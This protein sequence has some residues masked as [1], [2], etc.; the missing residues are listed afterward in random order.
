[1]LW[2][3]VSYLYSSS[4][5]SFRCKTSGLQGFCKCFFGLKAKS[6]LHI[7]AVLPKPLQI[8]CALWKSILSSCKTV[9]T[10]NILWK[11]FCGQQQLSEGWFKPKSHANKKPDSK[12]RIWMAAESN[13]LHLMQK[14]KNKKRDWNATMPKHS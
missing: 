2:C 7:F 11:G 3:L 8:N 12:C 6:N 1:M 10:N 9:T 14:N 5:G 13:N 4:F